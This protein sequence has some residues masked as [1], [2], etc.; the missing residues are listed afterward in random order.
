MNRWRRAAGASAHDVSVRPELWVPGALA[1]LVAI[2]WLPLIVV[3]AR[4]PSVSDLTFLGA[5]LVT[6]GAWPWSA[7]LIA[8]GLL[9]LIA[10]GFAAVALAN[11]SLIAT[12][13]ARAFRFDDA[14]RLLRISAVAAVPAGIA[15][16]FLLLTASIVAPGQFNAPDPPGGPVVSTLLRL[17]PQLAVDRGT[18]PRRA[19]DLG[20]WR[21]DHGDPRGGDVPGDS[22]GGTDAAA[23]A[24]A[25]HLAASVLAG[26]VLLVLATMLL[27]VLWAPIGASLGAFGDFDLATGLLLI[28]F[29]GVWLCIVL[30]GGALHAWSAV[31]WSRILAADPPGGI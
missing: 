31:T 30:A 26:V 15:L 28:G 4:P 9:S 12:V 3:V 23:A 7:V 8:A 10:L 21:P 13:G 22:P 16:G 14:L 24:V 17:V 2:G 25:I 29:V 11:A 5:R 6:S 1:W 27:G 20:R 19:G 18:R